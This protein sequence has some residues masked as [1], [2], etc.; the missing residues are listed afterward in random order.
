MKKL[1]YCLI[2]TFG[3]IFLSCKSQKEEVKRNNDVPDEIISKL[4]AAGFVTSEGLRIFED[5]YIVEYD[6]YL[7]ESQIDELVAQNSDQLA[8]GRAEHYA[9][10]WQVN[11]LPRAIQ[12]YMDPAFGT[13]M[14]NAFDE[15]LA[16]YN[17]LSISLRFA[18]ST[19]SS[20]A[21][22]RIISFYEVSSLLGISAGFPTGGNPANLIR[23]NTYHFNNT[24]TRADAATV[25]AHE[26]GHAIGFRHTD[27]MNRAYSCGSG[28]NEGDAGVGAVNIPGTPTA[29]SAGSW[30]LA[31][32]NG[33]N[34]PFTSQDRTSLL[35]L[36]P[37]TSTSNRYILN[38]GVQLLQGQ[39]MRS[40]D[41]RFRLTL[42]TDGNLVLY[43]NLNRALWHSN[44]HGRPYITRCLMQTDGNLVLYDNAFVPY[45]ASNTHMYPGAYL[46]LQDDG[47]L[48]IYQGSAA[49]WASN[50][51]CR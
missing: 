45:W 4:H 36:Y 5:G 20:S 47:N 8:N 2:M 25:I 27:F 30:M 1:T 7:T 37:P 6:I 42:Q 22:I 41:S 3:V 23:L 21:D 32:S 26:I 51:C 14:Q 43:D 16:R 10:T 29:P 48:V 49:R 9:T 12:V 28:G 19:S 33:T 15:A 39:S 40:I 24:T 13:Y 18:R 38:G 44:T 11:R 34:R 50:T 31:C 46:R 17:A 35:A